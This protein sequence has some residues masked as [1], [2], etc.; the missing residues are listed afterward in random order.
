[1][2]C[3]VKQKQIMDCDYLFTFDEMLEPR[4]RLPPKTIAISKLHK[5]HSII[6]I[7]AP[8]VRP[9][10]PLPSACTSRSLYQIPSIIDFSH[11]QVYKL[12]VPPKKT[13]RKYERLELK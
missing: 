11:A 5:S 7:T 1:M 12:T 4:E 6:M 9:P 10:Q 13:L 8:T 2:L 3:G